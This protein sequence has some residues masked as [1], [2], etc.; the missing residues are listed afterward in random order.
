[1]K[2]WI[3]CILTI[4]IVGIT[5]IVYR[6]R[7]MSFE[8]YLDLAEILTKGKLMIRKWSTWKRL[9]RSRWKITESCLW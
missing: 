6:G 5:A 8:D 2:K 4:L 3:I 1:M 9:W 7:T